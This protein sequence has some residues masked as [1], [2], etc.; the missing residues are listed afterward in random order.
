MSAKHR[1]LALALGLAMAAAPHATFPTPSPAQALS[2]EEAPASGAPDAA[3]SGSPGAR[4]EGVDGGLRGRAR[5]LYSYL[6]GKRVNIYSLYQS[7]I[8]RDFFTTEKALQNYIAHLTARLTARRFRKYRIEK[9]EL[10]GLTQAGPDR[11]HARVKLIGRHRQPFLFW[12]KT[13]TVVNEWRRMEG[14]WF[15]FPPPF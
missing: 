4:D 10:L 5:S 1:F 11:A 14:Q 9:T 7:E 8:F 6:E 3:A 12:D 2:P 13:E 15:V